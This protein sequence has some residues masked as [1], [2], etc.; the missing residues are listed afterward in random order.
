MLRF[1]NKRA[2]VNCHMDWECFSGP[3]YSHFCSTNTFQV[4]DTKNLRNTTYLP[5]WQGCY[6]HYNSPQNQWVI[7]QGL[8]CCCK[9]C[10]LII[11]KVHMRY[12]VRTHKRDIV[13]SPYT[14]YYCLI[15][16][17]QCE[18]TK[19]SSQTHVL[20][21]KII[22][23]WCRARKII[24]GRDHPVCWYIFFVSEKVGGY[25]QIKRFSHENH[26]LIH[27]DNCRLCLKNRYVLF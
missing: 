7:F 9:N 3:K 24:R 8:S 22:I 25:H 19:L 4:I 20:K 6:G 21:Q 23:V 15:F 10:G 2:G 1:F 17:A 13:C 27:D 14:T 5:Q 12:L 11:C 26:I 18:N 16:Q